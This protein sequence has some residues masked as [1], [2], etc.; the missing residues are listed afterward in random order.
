MSHV[1]D[2]GPGPQ[3][4]GRLLGLSAPFKSIGS[5]CCGVCKAA[6]PIEM[7]FEG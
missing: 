1:L 5:L 4:K 7:P 2:E 6:E 3:E